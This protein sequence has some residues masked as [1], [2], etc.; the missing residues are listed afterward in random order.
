MTT[1]F[2]L[3]LIVASLLLFSLATAEPFSGYVAIMHDK[4]TQVNDA[5]EQMTSL[6]YLAEGEAKLSEET[7]TF[8]AGVMY[9]NFDA[10]GEYFDGT[11]DILMDYGNVITVKFSKAS[12]GNELD[13]QGFFSIL[14]LP[15]QGQ[16][17]SGKKKY[18]G[19]SGFLK[20]Y[21]RVLPGEYNSYR[22]F[23][24]HVL[25]TISDSLCCCSLQYRWTWTNLLQL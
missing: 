9:D 18:K 13:S 5:D 14:P 24:S 1:P 20:M 12:I 2:L 15:L 17:V 21:G 16:I 6:E 3:L 8:K 7:L 25:T 11:I 19:A 23:A 10:K 4:E 22:C